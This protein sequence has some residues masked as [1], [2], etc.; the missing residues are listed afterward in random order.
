M[1][2]GAD[3]G[4]AQGASSSS[5][6]EVKGVTLTEAP[7]GRWGEVHGGHRLC[8]GHAQARES[9]GRADQAGE[10]GRHSGVAGAAARKKI[11]VQRG[12]TLAGVGV[13]R[14]NFAAITSGASDRPTALGQCR[15]L[16]GSLRR[17]PAL[18]AAMA[19]Q[20][21][22]DAT[23]TLF[24]EG[25]T[26]GPEFAGRGRSCRAGRANRVRS[27]CR[28]AGRNGDERSQRV[29]DRRLVHLAPGVTAGMRAVP[30][31]AP[32]CSHL[33]SCSNGALAHVSSSVAG[34]HSG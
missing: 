17:A 7:G 11:A 25:S 4:R 1:G 3:A 16:G 34:G 20:R 31:K 15:Q 26:A 32:L 8:R 10:A 14:R 12:S 33:A 19:D 22:V 23:V 6:A 28:G 24:L 5:M 13:R 30:S 2:S 18:A 27:R 9:R 21:V 29:G